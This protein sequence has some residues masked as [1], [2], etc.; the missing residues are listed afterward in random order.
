LDKIAALDQRCCYISA[1]ENTH[2]LYYVTEKLFDAYACQAIPIYAASESHSI[3]SWL[4][5][6]SYINLY[7]QAVDRTN[8][9]I[10]PFSVDG[11]FLEAYREVQNILAERF[12]SASALKSERLRV[13]REI[14]KELK[15]VC[16]A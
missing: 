7:N 15:T 12:S 6:S 16:D 14:Q 5:D 13:I 4:P 8:F 11:E 2:Q 9:Q 3:K 1:L 10:P